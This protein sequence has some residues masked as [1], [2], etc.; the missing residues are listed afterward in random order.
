MSIYHD[1][2]ETNELLSIFNRLINQYDELTEYEKYTL[3]LKANLLDNYI[4]YRNIIAF[5]NAKYGRNYTKVQTLSTEMCYSYKEDNELDF[6][7]RLVLDCATNEDFVPENK[8][9]SHK[10]ILTLI[11]TGIIY[12]IFARTYN[13]YYFNNSEIP[14]KTAE[15]YIDKYYDI[16]DDYAEEVLHDHSIP[17]F[18]PSEL[19][20]SRNTGEGFFML[21]E[22]TITEENINTF[23]RV[24][25][26][27]KMQILEDIKQ[28]I[29]DI[30]KSYEYYEYSFPDEYKQEKETL[31]EVR[32]IYTSAFKNK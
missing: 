28:I 30:M 12:P 27:S 21:N 20:L 15:T 7:G 26:I 13:G 32:T 23:S 8:R 6:V 31:S 5:I 22:S 10:E 16:D 25:P 9:Y 4:S 1:Y 3:L 2:K 14:F 19:N 18:V 24:L 11:K 29:E 17:V